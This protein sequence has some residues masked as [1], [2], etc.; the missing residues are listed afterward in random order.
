VS[1]IDHL[2]IGSKSR[3][4]VHGATLTDPDGHRVVEATGLDATINL[5]S[6][7]RSIQNGRGPAVELENVRIET[8]DV[9]L[10][11]DAQG[12]PLIAKALHPRAGVVTKPSTKK[13][14][15][16]TIPSEPYLDIAS[17][18]I[19]HGKVHGNMV[20]PALDGTTEGLLAR[21]HLEHEIVRIDLDEG[22]ATLHS[23]QAPN[24]KEPLVGDLKG[25]LSV[26]TTKQ[27]LSGRADFTGGIGPVPVVAHAQIDGD[28][29]DATIDVSRVVPSDRTKTNFVS[30]Y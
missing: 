5:R 26:D 18:R 23:P 19:D 25:V 10:S 28:V 3:V 22:K 24:Q 14:Q 29:V 27:T 15:T 2:E 8:A 1:G 6:L 16:A 30:I 13:P 21:V 17:A 11:R 7:V 12:T 20:P 9:E 4:K